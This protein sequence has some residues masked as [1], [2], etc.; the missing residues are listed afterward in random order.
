MPYT[1]RLNT[2]IPSAMLCLSSFQLYS[3]WVPLIVVFLIY[4]FLMEAIIFHPEK[5]NCGIV[6]RV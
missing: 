2:K 3:R 6:V 5:K 1:Y 4:F